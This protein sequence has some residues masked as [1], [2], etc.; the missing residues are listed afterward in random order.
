M[1]ATQLGAL[2]TVVAIITAIL[3]VVYM[4]RQQGREAIRARKEELA[5]AVAVAVDAE[6]KYS[7]SQVASVQQELTDMKN[8]RD[9]QR[10]RADEYEREL[11]NERHNQGGA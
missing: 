1:T 10:K 11:R 4:A 2:G 7:Q 9:Y 8:E 3:G 6:R 5:D